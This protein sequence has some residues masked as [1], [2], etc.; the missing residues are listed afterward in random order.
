[1]KAAEAISQSGRVDLTRPDHFDDFVLAYG[2]QAA[3]QARI[4][5]LIAR[6]AK[7]H[8]PAREKQHLRLMLL[9]AYT[10]LQLT[11]GN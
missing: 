1:M 3:W 11:K 2:P 9:N 7:P 5:Q 10:Q 8:L 4:N 6:E